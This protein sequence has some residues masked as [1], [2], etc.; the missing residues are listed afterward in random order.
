MTALC[1]YMN[2]SEG[3]KG[4]TRLPQFNCF[5]NKECLKGLPKIKVILQC[6]MESYG[7]LNWKKKLVIFKFEI[8]CQHVGKGTL[9]ITDLYVEFLM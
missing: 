2:D 8:I 6:K 4:I 3:E 5:W 9:P 1:V 7:L